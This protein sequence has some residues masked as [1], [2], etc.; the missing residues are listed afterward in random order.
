M[1]IR[2]SVPAAAL[3]AVIA[4]GDRSELNGFTVDGPFLALELHGDL[5]L[6]DALAFMDQAD[7][8]VGGLIADADDAEQI[9]NF[10]ALK[11]AIN[12]LRSD[13]T[14]ESY[15]QGAPISSNADATDETVI[16][17]PTSTGDAASYFSSQSNQASSEQQENELEQAPEEERN[18]RRRRG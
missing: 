7:A 12:D 13:V 4:I 5:S 17:H 15:I 3:A 16:S 11:R 1:L 14:R 9:A 18:P 8:Y 6:V 2:K 10:T